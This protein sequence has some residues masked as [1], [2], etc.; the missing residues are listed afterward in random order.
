[1]ELS[2]F[3]IF[4]NEYKK[5]E[6]HPDYTISTKNTEDKF[7]KVGACWKKKTKEGKTF[8]SCKLEQP[9][10]PLTEQEKA[11]LKAIKEQATQTVVQEYNETPF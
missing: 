1:M 10:P 2:S 6:K 7:V 4:P 8:L 5:E 11:D 9:K 3:S